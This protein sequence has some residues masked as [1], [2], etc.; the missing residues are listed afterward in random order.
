VEFRTETGTIINN[1]LSIG[2]NGAEERDI[3][4][5]FTF[6]W[7]FPEVEAGSA[8]EEEKRHIWTVEAQKAVHGTI[9]VIRQLAKDGQLQG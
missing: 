4:L 9:E 1:I 5:T 6:E 3:Y 8:E 7:Q 2:P